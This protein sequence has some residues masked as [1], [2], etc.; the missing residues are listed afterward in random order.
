MDKDSTFIE[1]SSLFDSIN[2]NYIINFKKSAESAYKI[3]VLPEGFTD[4]FGNVNDTLNYNLR[5][6][7]ESDFGYARFNLVNTEYPI[8]LQLTNEK[9]D[10][11]YEQYATKPEAIDFINL[12][13]GKYF[14]RVIHDANGNK[15][16][17]TGNYLKKIQPEKVSFF[18]EIEI[19]ADWGVSDILEFKE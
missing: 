12:D 11:K 10:V 15:I 4:F 5:T 17:D 3:K 13:A 2:N 16:F 9:G 19:R 6:R 18:K 8:I 14:I 7:K 1:F